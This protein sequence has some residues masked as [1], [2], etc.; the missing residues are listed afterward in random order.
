MQ[1]HLELTVTAAEARAAG[2][3]DAEGVVVNTGSEPVELDL[4]E[5]ASPSLALEIVDA[6]GNSL[7]M[8]PPPTP[9]RPNLM[10]MAPGDR[11]SIRF[12]AFA[13]LTERPGKY[14]VRFRYRDAK[15]DWVEFAIR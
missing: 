10:V 2:D 6:D 13:P 15:S 7:P 1:L 14:R 4:V 12:R 8:L 3:I 5:L 11:R 9:G